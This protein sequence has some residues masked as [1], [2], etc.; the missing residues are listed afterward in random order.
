LAG[1]H[2]DEVMRMYGATRAI[3]TL[4]GVAAAGVLL[5]LSSWMLDIEFR[6][7][8]SAGAYWAFV[9]LAAAAG[10]VLALSQLLGGWTKWGVP[11][12]SLPVLIVGFLPALVAGGLVLLATQPGGGWNSGR[13]TDLAGEVGAGNVVDDLGALF[14]VIAFGLGIVLG[15]VFDTAGSP[16]FVRRD[17]D[18]RAAEEGVAAERIEEAER[19]DEPAPAQDEALARSR[20]DSVTRRR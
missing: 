1:H 13:A 18:E 4:L 7:D 15:L 6:F 20:E 2:S 14:P 5:W 19:R 10:L 9:G 11:R 16:R 12:I 17:Y 3:V 8:G